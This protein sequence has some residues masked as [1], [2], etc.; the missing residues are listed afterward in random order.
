M[1]DLIQKHTDILGNKVVESLKKNRFEAEYFT[2]AK[3][4]RNRLLQIIPEGVKVGFGGSATVKELDIQGELL[5]R[6]CQI[7]DHNHYIDPVEKDR[8]SRL[9]LTCDVLVTSVN[10]L[11]ADGK[12]YS[13]DGKG[14]RVAAMIYG[15]Q[16]TILVVGINKLVK[17][18]D[19]AVARVETCAAPINN[20]RLNLPNPCVKSGVCSDCDSEKRICNVAVILHRR[21]SASHITVLVVG[22]SL[23]F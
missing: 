6:G 18:L 4:A 23:G 17:D 3:S 2:D 11:T 13:V 16:K 14:N 22:E 7:F 21:P 20:L 19:A 12:L 5:E 9:E 15:P 1:K 8:I 10:A